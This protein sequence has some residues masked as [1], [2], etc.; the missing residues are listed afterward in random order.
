MR[1]LCVLKKERENPN[2]CSKQDWMGEYSNSVWTMFLHLPL[3]FIYWFYHWQFI[4]FFLFQRYQAIRR[5]RRSESSSSS[6]LHVLWIFLSY[7]LTLT[8]CMSSHI[9]SSSVQPIHPP[10]HLP[11]F[12]CYFPNLKSQRIL[13]I[14]VCKRQGRKPPM[15]DCDVRSL[16]RYCTKNLYH[17]GMDITKGSGTL[18]KTTVS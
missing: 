11:P 15:N 3:Q 18:R 6:S 10:P 2:K 13:K 17:S 4:Y 1:T 7:T 14:A 5:S 8:I 9:H 12:H 16:R